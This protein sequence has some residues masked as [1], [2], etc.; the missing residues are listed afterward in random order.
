MTHKL[1]LKQIEKAIQEFDPKEQ[2]QL[3]QDLPYLLKI[4]DSDR[5]LLKTAEPSFDFW[6]NPDDQIYDKL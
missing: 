3:L 4:S 5:S 6:D 1:S 2:R